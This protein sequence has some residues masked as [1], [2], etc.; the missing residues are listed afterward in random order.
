MD[1][2]GHRQQHNPTHRVGVQALRIASSIGRWQDA[3]QVQIKRLLQQ[4]PYCG[5]AAHAITTPRVKALQLIWC[6]SYMGWM[7]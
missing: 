5:S 2:S 6:Q 4:K 3:V 7:G 1:A